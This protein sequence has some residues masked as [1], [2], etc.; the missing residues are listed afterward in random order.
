MKEEERDNLL[1]RLEERTANIWRYVEEIKTHQETQ[2]NHILTSLT[3]SRSNRLWIKVI[4][5][6]GGASIILFLTYILG[7]F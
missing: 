1:I 6:I 2:N 7:R 3:C 4:S 5:G